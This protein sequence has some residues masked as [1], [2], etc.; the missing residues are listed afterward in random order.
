MGLCPNHL[1][2]T[3]SAE[4]GN[5]YQVPMAYTRPDILATASLPCR[6]INRGNKSAS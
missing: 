4:Q 1:R 2:G 5:R 3:A 6:L